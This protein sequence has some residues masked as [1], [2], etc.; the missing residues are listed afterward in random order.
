MEVEKI[1]H[2]LQEKEKLIS[3]LQAQ[4]DQAQ[5]EQ[6]SQV[7]VSH[8]VMIRLQVTNGQRVHIFLE[9]QRIA[10]EFCFFFSFVNASF[11]TV[12]NYLPSVSPPC[13]PLPPSSLPSKS[14]DAVV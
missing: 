14:N 13:L 3:S 9:G 12:S 7:G 4:L 10:F 5:S 8:L 6:A 1:K 11:Y 2:E